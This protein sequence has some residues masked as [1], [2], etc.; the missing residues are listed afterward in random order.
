MCVCLSYKCV[1]EIIKS[2]DLIL[3]LLS[4]IKELGIAVAQLLFTFGD[5]F[6]VVAGFSQFGHIV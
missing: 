2:L 6:N 5:L 3:E 4:F 1:L